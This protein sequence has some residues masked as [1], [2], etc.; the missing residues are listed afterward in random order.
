MNSMLLKPKTFVG[1]LGNF[2]YLAAIYTPWSRFY[3]FIWEWNCRNIRVDTYKNYFDL[4]KVLKTC[5]WVPDGWKRLWSAYSNVGTIQAII[6]TTQPGQRDI[7]DC[8]E[9]AVYNVNAINASTLEPWNKLY[10]LSARILTILWIDASGTYG[11]HDVCLIEWFDPT[12]T[13]HGSA[14]DCF[15][16]MDYDQPN[17]PQYDINGV[18][19]Q[20]I[21]KYAPGG[22]ILA[23]SIR[24]Q[25][26]KVQQTHW[27][28]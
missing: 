22:T 2:I 26:L 4:A 20:I 25:N 5:I 23:W 7:G 21:G 12:I 10:T 16:Y 28:R 14:G 24:D 11:G 19:D 13:H 8:S 18:L 3:Q 9:F 27:G 17:A 15:S 1:K 6:N